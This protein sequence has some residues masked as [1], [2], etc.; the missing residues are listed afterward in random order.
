MQIICRDRR[1]ADRSRRIP[2]LSLPQV[3]R[4]ESQDYEGHE[5]NLG[6][7][8]YSFFLN[9]GDDVTGAFTVRLTKLSTLTMCNVLF[10]ITLSKAI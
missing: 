6:S 10:S 1:S 2:H 8:I 4:M 3:G 7:M 5:E 9:H